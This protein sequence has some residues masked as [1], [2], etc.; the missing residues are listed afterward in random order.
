MNNKSNKLGMVMII[1]SLIFTAL[2]GAT[3]VVYN[4]DLLGL[5][6]RIVLGVSVGLAISGVGVYMSSKENNKFNQ[7]IIG[8]GLCTIHT[9]LIISGQVTDNI[10]FT[11]VS[12]A[13]IMATTVIASKLKSTILTISNMV[14]GYAAILF[15]INKELVDYSVINT[16]ITM[17]GFLMINISSCLISINIKNKIIMILDTIIG[18]FVCIAMIHTLNENSGIVLLAYCL[19]NM[20][21][22][23]RLIGVNKE[24]S[25]NTVLV[26]NHLGKMLV[27]L[28]CIVTVNAWL[29][30]LTVFIWSLYQLYNIKENGREIDKILLVIALPIIGVSNELLL[31]SMLAIDCLACIYLSKDNMLSG[32]N[33]EVN[34]A[35]IGYILISISLMIASMIVIQT[36]FKEYSYSDGQQALAVNTLALIIQSIDMLMCLYVVF[37]IKYNDLLNVFLA[38]V[39]QKISVV[40]AISTVSLFIRFAEFMKHIQTG[41]DG[42][43]GGYAISSYIEVI[44]AFA[45]IYLIYATLNRQAKESVKRGMELDILYIDSIV[46]SMVMIIPTII[47]SVIECYIHDTHISDV[48]NVAISII[49]SAIVTVSILFTERQMFKTYESLCRKNKVVINII[50]CLRGL[51]DVVVLNYAIFNLIPENSIGSTGMGTIGT[52]V[53]IIYTIFII[54]KQYENIKKTNEINSVYVVS[55]SIAVVTSVIW[56]ISIDSILIPFGML[57]LAGGTFALGYMILNKD[58]IYGKGSEIK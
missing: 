5:V 32:S 14:A 15:G 1:I 34:G 38:V 56:C 41:S 9:I 54:C 51:A 39:Y 19:M 12:I 11:S 40:M 53:S 29:V 35:S 20:I 4:W 52:L 33:K 17:I 42:S 30:S 13:L 24:L 43:I 16:I 58:R 55:Y 46:E 50:G 6:G 18:T 23:Q 26:V 36:T 3:L 45:I 22:V 21:L 8:I 37:R 31:M 49:L 57:L 44:G 47:V 10:M 25:S 7:S 2:F 28:N 48:D 27:I